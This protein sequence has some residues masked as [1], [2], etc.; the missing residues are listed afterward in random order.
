M[1]GF[2]ISNNI[3]SDIL[4]AVR[5]PRGTTRYASNGG[6]E[7]LSWRK[8]KADPYFYF[9]DGYRE[10]RV[11]DAKTEAEA[12]AETE[13]QERMFGRRRRRRRRR[14]KCGK[15]DCC[16]AP[17]EVGR[18]TSSATRPV[19]DERV[20]PREPLYPYNPYHPSFPPVS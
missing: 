20:D 6:A 17:L 12:E 11:K 4:V 1:F 5:K 8:E 10:G 3:G 19:K 9:K 13:A 16:A 15:A 18:K 7:G 14:R 2:V